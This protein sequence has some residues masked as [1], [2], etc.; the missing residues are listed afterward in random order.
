MHCARV[1]ICVISALHGVA[2]S[3]VTHEVLGS[4][5]GQPRFGCGLRCHCSVLAGGLASNLLIVTAGRKWANKGTESVNWD[6]G[7]KG[8][9]KNK[10]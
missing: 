2:I 7:G 8:G 9:V 4:G 3:V 1:R 10:Y 5:T 6:R